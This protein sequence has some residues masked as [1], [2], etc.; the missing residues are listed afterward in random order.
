M[1]VNGL[2]LLL[3]VIVV[4][5]WAPKDHHHLDILIYFLFCAVCSSA[6]TILPGFTLG[7]RCLRIVNRMGSVGFEVCMWHVLYI[8]L[9]FAIIISS[10]YGN[11]SNE[12]V[13]VRLE[14]NEEWVFNNIVMTLNDKTFN[15][16]TGERVNGWTGLA[17]KIWKW[18]WKSTRIWIQN[19]VHLVRRWI[20]SKKHTTHEKGFLI[21][22]NQ[23]SVVI[24]L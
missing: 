2:Y 12:C 6:F 1:A 4:S 10:K 15:W 21:C 7:V 18:A 24:I 19:C 3:D 13:N 9:L 5:D 20:D 14:S 16:W 22:L 17:L 8:L 23:I 11:A